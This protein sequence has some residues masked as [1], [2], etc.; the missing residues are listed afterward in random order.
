MYAPERPFPLIDAVLSVN[1]NEV[2]PQPIVSVELGAKI[3]WRVCRDRASGWWVGACDPL[4]LTAEGETFA[5]LMTDIHLV[6]Q[7]FFRHLLQEG[8]LDGC[9]R[10]LG[11]K[12]AHRVSVPPGVDAKHARFDI[13][14]EWHESRPAEMHA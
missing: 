10:E 13:P 5:D 11:W 2:E 14:F 3:S 4:R 6:M 7:D 1:L 8:D 12:H 9:L